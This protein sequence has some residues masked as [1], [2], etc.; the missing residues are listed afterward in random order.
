MAEPPG[1]SV[2]IC[3][4]NSA[5][6]IGV[7]LEHLGRQE[8]PPGIPWEVILVDNASTDETVAVAQSVWGRVGGAPLQVVAES[9]LGLSHA[10]E[11]GLA[12]AGYAFVSL[13]DDDNWV[14]CDWI[15]RVFE[16]LTVHPEVA[17]VGGEAQAVCEEP[18]PD[19]FEAF[20][21]CYA[22]GRQAPAD[23]DITESRGYVWGAG[24]SLRRAAWQA[25]TEAGYRPLLSDR[26][27]GRL[28]CGG[29]T[30]LCY[31]LRLAGWRIR[32]EPALTLRHY[33][34]AARLRWNHLRGIMRGYGRATVAF[35]GYLD[36]W[37][38][39]RPEALR[40]RSG[41]LWVPRSIETLRRLWSR[42]R[43]W[44]QALASAGE[45]RWEVL[46][47]DRDMARLTTLLALRGRYD[48]TARAMLEAPWRVGREGQGE[49]AAGR[50]GS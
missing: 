17:V 39:R 23:G 16:T 6:R 30:E 5:G 48:R 7:T 46:E 15:A 47:V 33:M 13:V 10:R 35:D 43:A 4:H 45:G 3:C 38:R 28:T 31:A 29:D 19:W 49:R 32:Y 42:R 18:P 26:Q 41:T 40:G 25:L 34:P 37:K 20:Q 44:V 9:R 24:L 14:A 8:V 36:A 2:V 50:E 21:H 12:S 22:V 27:G 1:V 11:R